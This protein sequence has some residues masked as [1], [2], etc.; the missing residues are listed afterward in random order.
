MTLTTPVKGLISETAVLLRLLLLGMRVYSG[1]CDG[2]DDWLICAGGRSFKIQVKTI[3]YKGATPLIRTSK[4]NRKRYTQADC[5]FLVGYSLLED[6]C[7][8]LPVMEAKERSTSLCDMN[9]DN[10]KLLLS[11]M[12]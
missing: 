7:Y 10:W 2:A 3:Y 1:L 8:I 9:R 5:D 12:E 11:G 4:N 6:C